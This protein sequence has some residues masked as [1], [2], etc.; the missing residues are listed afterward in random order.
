[1]PAAAACGTCNEIPRAADALALV[2]AELEAAVDADA[3][4]LDA[5]DAE[6]ADV[7]DADIGPE[8]SVFVTEAFTCS[9]DGS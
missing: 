3:D 6:I 4:D 8:D 1:M 2:V 5:A 7:E 9:A